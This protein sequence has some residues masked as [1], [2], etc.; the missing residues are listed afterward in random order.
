MQQLSEAQEKEVQQA[1]DK[2]SRELKM[3]ITFYYRSTKDLNL[4]IQYALK[5]RLVEYEDVIQELDKLEPDKINQE[6]IKKLQKLSDITDLSDTI[7]LKD[8]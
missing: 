3:S 8:N 1:I 2:I 4:A 6:D 5:N 7:N